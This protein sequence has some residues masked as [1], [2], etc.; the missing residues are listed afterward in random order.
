MIRHEAVRNNS[1]RPLL[2]RF[3]QKAFKSDIFG[4]TGE[5]TALSRASI[6]YVTG[7]AAERRPWN[8]R[9]DRRNAKD[10]PWT[11]G[12]SADPGQTPE[13]VIGNLRTGVRPRM[14]DDTR[15]GGHG[16]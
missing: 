13:R 11:E 15:R 16:R 2:A 8:S 6:E 12:K 10:G 3:S 5:K 14:F 9:H 1:H 4:L 7:D